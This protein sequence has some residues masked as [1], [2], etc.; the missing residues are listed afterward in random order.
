MKTLFKNKSDSYK[1]FLKMHKRHHKEQV[2][3]AKEFCEWRWWDLHDDVVQRIK[4]ML[5]YYVT[6]DNVWQCMETREK[7]IQQ[8][9]EILDIA[10]QIEEKEREADNFETPEK[11]DECQTKIDALYVEMYKKIGENIQHW[12]D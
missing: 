10:K 4:H 5:E 7:I 8:L 3:R 2:A 1:N 6:G 9:E 12:Y 11:Y